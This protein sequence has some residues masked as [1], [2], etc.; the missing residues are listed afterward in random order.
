MNKEQERLLQIDSDKKS[1]KKWGPYL[2]ERQW[3]TVREDYSAQGSAW[4]SI[5]H[6]MA[7]SKT[8]RWGEEG[9]AGICDDQQLLCFSVAL[10]N[11]KDPILKERMFGLTGNEGN[12]GEDVKE[13]YYYL[14]NT[15]THSYM[16]MLYK[17]PQQEFPYAQLLSEN[18]NRSKLETE[19]ELIDTGIFNENKY[20]DVYIEFAKNLPDDILIKISVV[21]RGKEDAHLNVIPQLWFRNTW[22]WGYDDYKPVMY[23]KDKNTITIEHRQLG[24]IILHCDNNP[25]LLFCDNETNTQRLYGVDGNNKYHKDGINNFIVNGQN[26]AVNPEMSGTRA[27]A[28]YDITVKAGQTETILLRL[29]PSGMDNPFA[30]FDAIFTNRINEADEFYHELQK[31]LAS[32]DEKLVQRQALS[33]MLWNKQF[34]YYDVEQWLKG[35]PAQPAPPNA[36][37]EGRNCEWKHL[38]T[39]DIISMPDK[40]EYPW[41]ASWDLAF[42]CIA[43]SLVDRQFAKSQLELL[44]R[45]WFMHPNG[46]LP[47]CE[48]DFDNANPPLHAY[49]AWRVY[50]IDMKMNE[51]KGDVKFLESI[52]HKLIINFTWWVN[53]KDSLGNNLFEGGF[54]G[55]DNI[56]VFDRSSRLPDGGFIE[57]SDGT[58]WMAMYSLTMMHISLELAKSNPVYQD[59]ATKFFEHFLYIAASMESMGEEGKGLWDEE[60]QFYYDVLNLKETGRTKIKL[61]SLVGLIPLFAVGILDDELLEMPEFNARLNWFFEHRP[62]LSGL[63]S[64]WHDKN[65]ASMH[66]LSL[67]RGHRLKR[68]LKRMLDE[69]EFLSPYGI[70]SLS[71]YHEQHPYILQFDH[72][73]FTVKYCPGE[74]ES[75]LFGGNSNWRGPIWIPLNFL[76]IESLQRFHYYY[77]DDFK[78]EY[79]TGSGNLSTLLE[80]SED[81]RKRVTLLFLKDGSGKRPVLGYN[82]FMQSSAEFNNYILFHE[83]FHGDNGRGAGASHQTG[84]TGLIAKIIQ[85]RQ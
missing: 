84:W 52:F 56:S 24:E 36:R 1:W 22:A 67:L 39:A 21:N 11:N 63:V 78:V 51:D 46:Q 82:E 72:T 27:A 16:K 15:P 69:S 75:T 7:R 28:N 49:A 18:I 74:S 50:K 14:D 20:F 62:D 59:M 77:G 42:H 64:H 83:Y 58:S 38:N 60:D 65:K 55:L 44:I 37:L 26:A 19:F 25:Q 41:F 35:D 73:E 53:R 30:G 61:R 80:I 48:W 45:E 17:Y 70:R 34:Y 12:H 76:I 2:A 29:E 71:K 68:I 85:P 47:A 4:E 54:L 43:L 66:L 32:D 3:G 10:W 13:L 9:I 8:Y 5:T 79:P 31:D 33:G 40:W 81:I 57:Q 23:S 6:D